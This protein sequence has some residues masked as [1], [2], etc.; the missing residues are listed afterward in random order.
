MYSIWGVQ[1]KSVDVADTG[2][3]AK[4]CQ[5]WNLTSHAGNVDLA[6]FI[7]HALGV[8]KRLCALMGMCNFGTES[9]ALWHH[10]CRV[11]VESTA[12]LLIC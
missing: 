2:V 9:H 7:W 5:F 12:S 3:V 10:E 1:E 11:H 4:A 8:A 6:Q